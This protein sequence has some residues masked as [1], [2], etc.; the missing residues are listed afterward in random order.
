MLYPIIGIVAD[1]NDKEGCYCQKNDYISAVQGSGG[2]PIILPPLAAGLVEEFAARIDGLILAGGGDLDPTH[3]GEDSQ[4]EIQYTHPLRD[5]F[6]LLLVKATLAQERPILGIC[7]GIQVLNVAMG[8]TLYQDIQEQIGEAMIHRQVAPAGHPTH[9]VKVE[10]GSLL[11][12]LV[13]QPM[14]QVNSFHHQAVRAVAPGLVVS[15]WANKCTIEAIEAPS[16]HFVLGVQWHPETMWE[17]D[18]LAKALFDGLIESAKR[19]QLGR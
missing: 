6:E 12:R 4:Y 7:R 14:L 5:R 15:A 13:G 1:V 18:K 10:P 9:A 17:K 3:Y 19:G 8:G 11:A 16:H 2:L